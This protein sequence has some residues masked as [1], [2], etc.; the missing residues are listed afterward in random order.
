[1]V[2][3]PVLAAGEQEDRSP[4]MVR[5]RV[6]GRTAEPGTLLRQEGMGNLSGLGEGEYPAQIGEEGNP[7]ALGLP[8]SGSGP[9]AREGVSDRTPAEGRGNGLP[10][11]RGQNHGSD[12]RGGGQGSCLLGGRIRIPPSPLSLDHGGNPPD[13]GN[14]VDAGEPVSIQSEGA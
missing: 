2:D 6:H 10:G 14:R 7:D 8:G 11:N 4:P 3:G 12:G 5:A 13:L 9:V 1:M